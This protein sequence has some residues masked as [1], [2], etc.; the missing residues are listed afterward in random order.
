[1]FHESWLALDAWTH[2]KLLIPIWAV[3]R[4]LLVRF[5]IHKNVNSY[6]PTKISL[7]SSW[8]NGFLLIAYM[9]LNDIFS[10]TG[11]SFLSRKW[12]VK[13]IA[14]TAWF[15]KLVETTCQPLPC[16]RCPRN[17]R[18]KVLGIQ[19][20]SGHNGVWHVCIRFH[21]GSI[22]RHW[23]LAQVVSLK[24]CIFRVCNRSKVGCSD[25]LQDDDRKW[26]AIARGKSQGRISMSVQFGILKI[27]KFVQLSRKCCFQ[28]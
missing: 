12:F 28:K 9:S 5:V 1:M 19:V 4:T 27:A 23:I 26:V 3:K 17:L 15:G 18:V 7:G 16:S 13:P 6:E 10:F 21:L 11:F 14:V 22:K 2:L 20:R 8:S 25:D 24:G